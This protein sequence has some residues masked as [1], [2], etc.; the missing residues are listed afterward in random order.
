MSQFAFDY[1]LLVFVSSLAAIQ[2]AA[3]FGGLHG[4]LFVKHTLVTRAL[5]GLAITAVFIWFFADEPRNIN[6][7]KGGLDANYQG[8]LFCYGSLAAVAVTLAASSLVNRRMRDGEA[9]PDEG[10]DALRKTSYY[11]ALK[12]ILVFWWRNWPTR[13]KQYF[14]G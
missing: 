2:I 5:G 13:M 8:I 14:F 10:F 1:L 6:D 11:S 9:P 3:T 4:L 12:V 7:Y